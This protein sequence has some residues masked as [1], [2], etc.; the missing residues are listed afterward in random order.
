MRHR[1]VGQAGGAGRGTGRRVGEANNIILGRTKGPYSGRIK[2]QRPAINQV[3]S[4]RGADRI[5]AD[6][7][8]LIATLASRR[9]SA[10]DDAGRSR[11]RYTID[12][13]S[14]QAG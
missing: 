14:T 12:V 4:I 6:G 2:R 7:S 10:V 3:G 9:E 13:W 1:E 11:S 8:E 5:R